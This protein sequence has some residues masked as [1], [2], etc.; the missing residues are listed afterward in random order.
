[1]ENEI[2]NVIDY[3]DSTR[4]KELTSAVWKQAVNNQPFDIAE[5]SA[6]EYRYFHKFYEISKQL[7]AKQITKEQAAKMN[8]TNYM[9]FEFD[10]KLWEYYNFSVMEWN[11]N[12]ER[13]K[14]LRI[15]FARCSDI[16]TGYLI[17]ADIVSRLTGDT[18]IRLDAEMKAGVNTSESTKQANPESP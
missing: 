5:D 15:D 3:K 7:V 18:T 13:V 6:N 11:Q 9:K 8:D 10:Q 2:V 16:K 12:Q 17:L 1:M 14:Q 4:Y